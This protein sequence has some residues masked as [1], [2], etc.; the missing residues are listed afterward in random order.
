MKHRIH[1]KVCSFLTGIW[2]AVGAGQ[3]YA[4]A[5]LPTKSAL[6]EPEVISNSPTTSMPMLLIQTML[7][8]AL[9]IGLIYI[10]FR[11][12]GKRTNIFFGR[13]AIRSLG[14]CSVGPQKSV[15]II[16]VGSSLYLVGVGEDINL[17]RHIEGE[18]VD[19]IISLLESQGQQSVSSI[20]SFQTLMGR[21]SKKQIDKGQPADRNFQALF[22]SKMEEAKQRR[23]RVEKELFN[24]E[25]K[26]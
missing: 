25:E 13:T 22:Q 14:G 5:P 3:T 16:Q 2:W 8:L 15:Q 12:L 18:E 9:I 7:A 19:E 23:Q 6:N 4:N 17:L 21:I 10:L 11:F 26:E 24:E 1:L 20:S